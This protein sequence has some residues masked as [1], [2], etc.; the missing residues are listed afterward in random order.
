MDRRTKRSALPIIF[1]KVNTPGEDER[2]RKTWEGNFGAASPKNRPTSFLCMETE[3]R[4]WGEI[5]AKAG[6]WVGGGEDSSN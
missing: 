2:V 5:T 6:G 3:Q 1:F 4:G